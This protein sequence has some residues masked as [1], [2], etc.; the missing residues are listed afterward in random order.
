[1]K[2]ED[3]KEWEIEEAKNTFLWIKNYIFTIELLM[4]L[5]LGFNLKYFIGFSRFDLV[6]ASL[7][8]IFALSI[9]LSY[10]L[11]I[12]I[13]F[14]GQILETDIQISFDYAYRPILYISSTTTTI[15]LLFF[16]L[17]YI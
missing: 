12:A 17:L 16:E 14:R 3:K 4:F 5:A 9:F 13:F 15:I 1:M 6:I 2:K 8:L 10:F 7:L 11:Y